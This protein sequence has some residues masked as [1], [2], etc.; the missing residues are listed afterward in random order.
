M[1]GPRGRGWEMQ[2]GRFWIT[3]VGR[4]REERPAPSG[5]TD[6]IV[7]AGISLGCLAHAGDG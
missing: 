5:C 2:D 6:G 4:Y 7:R 1:N 3:S